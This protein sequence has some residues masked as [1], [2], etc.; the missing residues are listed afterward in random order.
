VARQRELR[1]HGGN[2][3]GSVVCTKQPREFI[4][5]ELILHRVACAQFLV[6]I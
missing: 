3:G 1:R 5:D 4:R 6:R 2:V